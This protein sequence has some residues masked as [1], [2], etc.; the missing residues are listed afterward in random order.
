MQTPNDICWP[1]D[2]EWG[3]FN[4]SIAGYLIQTAPPAAPCYAGPNRDAAACEAVTQGWST[5]T[6]Q[7][8]QPI[9]Y[10]YP[11]N[12][13]CPLAQFTANAPSAN[14]TIGNP[15]VF[16]VNVTDEEH[17]SKAV[18]F[19]KK[20][21]IR[22]VSKSTGHDFL[23]RSARSNEVEPGQANNKPKVDRLRQ[24]FHLVAKLSKRF[25]FP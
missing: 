5:A 15:P 6:F 10:D 14:C 19:A 4:S 23:Q 25:Q 13:S 18:E 7:A 16:A 9:G 24:P 21:N 2:K 12:S 1:S 17:I 3:R 20:N 8:S 11:L 22:V